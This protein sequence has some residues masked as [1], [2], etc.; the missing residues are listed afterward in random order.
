MLNEFLLRFRFRLLLSSTLALTLVMIWPDAS[1]WWR[2]ISIVGLVLAGINTLRH[3]RGLQNTA[4]ILGGFNLILLLLGEL[5]VIPRDVGQIGL[6]ALYMMLCF[7]LIRRVTHERPVTGE[8]LYGMCALYL[9]LAL[10]FA[11]AFASLEFILPGAFA[12]EAQLLPLGLDDFTY[13]SLVSLTTV[14]YG[15]IYPIHPLARI[16]A[17]LEAVTGVL[18]IALAVA[19]SLMLISDDNDRE[20]D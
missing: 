20:L 9:Q 7:A 10:A 6:I 11:M 16:L 5:E 15:D 4:F 3:K 1:P 18:F 13:F 2:G 8:L 19:R 17:T 14:G 12:A